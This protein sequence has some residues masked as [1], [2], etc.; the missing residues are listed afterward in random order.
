MTLKNVINFEHVCFRLLEVKYF[1]V[2]N[3]FILFYPGE[4]KNL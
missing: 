2:E 3:T 1:D 4:W